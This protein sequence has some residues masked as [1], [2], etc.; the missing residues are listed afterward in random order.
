MA[1]NLCSCSGYSDFL[2]SGSFHKYASDGI[3]NTK[4]LVY[5]IQE[6]VSENHGLSNDEYDD[7]LK[8]LYHQDQE[9]HNIA[10]KAG[11][12]KKIY[13]LLYVVLPNDDTGEQVGYLITAF[14]LLFQCSDEY[15][16]SCF[17]SIG[18]KLIPLLL[19][20][21]DMCL[22]GKVVPKHSP[23]LILATVTKILGIF[24][25]LAETRK[26]M[27][28]NN[29]FLNTLVDII[30]SKVSADARVYAVWS[31]SVLALDHDSRLLLTQHPDIM[32]TLIEASEIDDPTTKKEISAAILNMSAMAEAHTRLAQHDGF[33]KLLHKFLITI[34]D[35]QIRAAGTI[36][37]LASNEGARYEIVFFDK[38]AM[39]SALCFTMIGSKNEVASSRAA[40]AIK[41]LSF[42]NDSCVQYAMMDHP[43]FLRSVGRAISSQFENVRTYACLALI[44]FCNHCRHPMKS[45]NTLLTILADASVALNSYSDVVANRVSSAFLAQAL[46][47]ENLMSMV[48]K[49]GILEGI[50]LLSESK[51]PEARANA[52]KTLELLTSSKVGRH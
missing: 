18:Q 49:Q 11:L 48:K 34:G 25:K 32:D 45:H 40:G 41:N 44:N 42:S 47:Q 37:N 24:C 39:L 26:V 22:Q 17:S 16:L 12:G 2:D 51:N 43:R 9:R 52:T 7:L 8:S 33:L 1:A 3:V 28:S 10:I 5:V 21:C 6:A 38:G 19:D 46:Q 50:T 15:K 29:D 4:E 23:E 36:R 27:A 20:V 14:A 31:I 35:P 30:D 13:K